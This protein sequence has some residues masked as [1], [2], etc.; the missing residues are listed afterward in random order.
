M[1]SYAQ[2]LCLRSVLFETENT[3][4]IHCIIWDDD[5]PN[6]GYISGQFQPTKLV[7]SLPYN[8]LYPII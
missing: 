3:I 6:L 4:F 8:K 2:G 5:N 7:Y 1:P